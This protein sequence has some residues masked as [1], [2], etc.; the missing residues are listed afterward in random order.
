MIRKTS[1]KWYSLLLI[2]VLSHIFTQQYFAQVLEILG[3]DKNSSW[4]SFSYHIVSGMCSNGNLDQQIFWHVQR[5]TKKPWT[6]F[7]VQTGS[8]S[9]CQEENIWLAVSAIS[10]CFNPRS[11]WSDFLYIILKHVMTKYPW[12]SWLWHESV[13]RIA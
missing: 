13:L 11:S 7:Q 5:Q 3:R 10:F 1:L 4:I 6:F 12:H 2:L 8:P 9:S